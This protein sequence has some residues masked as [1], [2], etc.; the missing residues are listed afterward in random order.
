MLHMIDS[1]QTWDLKKIADKRPSDYIYA[2]ISNNVYNGTQLKVDAILPGKI[3][4]TIQKTKSGKAG[5]FGA[6]YINNKDKHMVLAHRGTD[7]FKAILEDIKGIYFNEIS[8]QK[9]EAF[10][11]VKEAVKLAQKLGF[12][13]SFTGHSLGAFLA[14]LSVFYCKS[15]LN[16]QDVNAVTFESP[17]SL[18]SL[19]IIQSNLHSYV[20]KL[21]DLD[22]I[23]Y[24]SYPNL[25]NT[26]NGHISTLYTISSDLGKYGW[27]PINYTKQAHSMDGIV[28]VFNN[29]PRPLE[30]NCLKDW[31]IGNQ[32][33]YFFS[34]AK[35]EDGAYSLSEEELIS[36]SEKHFQIV[37]E[38][39]YKVN[40]F[41]SRHNI[42]P[43]RHFNTELQ[44]FLIV[45]YKWQVDICPNE[46]ERAVLN[47]KL[48]TISISE[49]II[50]CLL[51]YKLIEHNQLISVEL[52]N[53]ASDI[54]VFRRELS[55]VLA[56]HGNAIKDLLTKQNHGSVEVIATV[57][58]SGG[59]VVKDGILNS[60]KALGLKVTV[61]E[62]T[63]HDNIVSV[64]QI[65]E[66][67]Q[68]GTNKI[69]S[70][71]V[72]PDAEVSGRIENS[73]AIGVEI[74]LTQRQ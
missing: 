41:L 29:N 4:W 54:L 10:G 70:H 72:A 59:K 58:A 55:E 26:C 32:R 60:V 67:I 34:I 49:N 63:S 9:K 51:G 13:L 18:G 19:Q 20:I 64:K 30:I 11:L 47:E 52:L 5:Y 74:D 36:N 12:T 62:D 40:S 1:L 6:I 21:E 31:P 45:F 14:E 2:L 57:V 56:I 25:V 69:T 61:P 23:G 39:H 53:T 42:L 28:K 73:Q 65:L 8:P 66:Q 50:N 33:D 7:S 15:E 16:F 46:A 38:S 35:F 44:K 24:V 3:D 71:I 37:Y 22:I 48:K 27:V 17:G 43:L 68:I